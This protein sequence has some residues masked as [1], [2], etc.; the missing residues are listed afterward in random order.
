MSNIV[1]AD[2]ISANIEVD[3]KRN[4]KPKS[5]NNFFENILSDKLNNNESKG[6]DDRKVDSTRNYSK[7]KEQK[8]EKINLKRKG[9]ESEQRPKSKSI[10]HEEKEN[11]EFVD[12]RNDISFMLENIE[13]IIDDIKKILSDDKSPK[14]NNDFNSLLIQLENIKEENVLDLKLEKDIINLTGLIIT[15]LQSYEE[16]KGI[17]MD[18]ELSEL[19][20]KL[21]YLVN[22]LLN[23]NELNEDFKLIEEFADKKDNIKKPNIY[24]EASENKQKRE[25][26]EIRLVNSIKNEHYNSI[27]KVDLKEDEVKEDKLVVGK[28]VRIL[29]V[30]NQTN[31][32][33]EKINNA[34][35]NILNNYENNLTNE[36][37]LLQNLDKNMLM[38]QIIEKLSLN[39]KKINPEVRIKLKPEILGNLFLNITTKDNLVLARITVENYQVKQVIEANLDVLKDNLKEQGL[40]IYEF[41]VDIGQ[42]ANFDNYN[43]QSRYNRNYFMK[44]KVSRL[45]NQ[46]VEEEFLYSNEVLNSFMDS[47]IDLKA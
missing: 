38:K 35:E 47:S 33:I 15:K 13:E 28:N 44:Q 2:F 34:K 5:K 45:A 43:S 14:L 6:V 4:L 31:S 29:T 3:I 24:K 39:N 1:A 27:A 11:I 17:K 21:N 18:K 9:N 30:N 40:E 37:T 16:N 25:V 10:N 19:F 26:R 36:R 20:S 8:N 7:D 23:Q 22:E 12:E 46:G 41:S 32:L 42:S